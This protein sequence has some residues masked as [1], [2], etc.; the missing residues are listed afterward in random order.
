MTWSPY[1]PYSFFG[2]LNKD[3]L[4]AL[5]LCGLSLLLYVFYDNVYLVILGGAGF[6]GLIVVQM[7]RN[8]R[9]RLLYKY[10]P[11]GFPTSS[12]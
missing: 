8:H 5:I 1:D 6:V 7:I 11:E 3:V 12:S 9:R 2:H 10:A 4:I